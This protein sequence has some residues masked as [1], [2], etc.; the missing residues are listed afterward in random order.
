M[1]VLIGVGNYSACDDGIGLRI[2]EHI[3]EK[4]LDKGFR[5]VDLSS[6][7]LN[8]F[9]YLHSGTE[10]LL[11]VDSA[12]MGEKP[13][14]YLFFEPSAA[15]SRKKLAGLSAHEG[16]V[17]KVLELAREMKAPIPPML[18]MGIEPKSLKGGMGLSKALE[19]RVPEYA[20][21]AIGKLFEIR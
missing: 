20:S 18:I 5:A 17:I 8:L 12:K 9:S 2:I 15:R 4:G 16:D 14:D 3:A 7:S 10:A 21:A 19:N 6:N 11:I 13:G 1:R